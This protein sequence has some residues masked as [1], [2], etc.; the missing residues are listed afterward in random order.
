MFDLCPK[1]ICQCIHVIHETVTIS[2]HGKLLSRQLHTI[3][4]KSCEMS[5]H[6]EDS[7]AGSEGITALDGG[8]KRVT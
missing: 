8:L 6:N 4:V 3:Y 5:I 1:D 2:L 7:V